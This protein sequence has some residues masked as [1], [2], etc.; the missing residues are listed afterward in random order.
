MDTEQNIEWIQ[1]LIRNEQQMET[2]GLID[3]SPVVNKDHIILSSSIEFLKNL[4]SQFIANAD[5]FNQL[6]GSSNGLIKVYGIA[7]THADFM[8]FRN[9]YKL[10]FNML[11]P[12]KI[13]ITF[14]HMSSPF[15]GS[16]SSNSN[17]AVIPDGTIEAAW[18]AFNEIRWVSD[19]KPVNADHLVKFYLRT[20]VQ[21]STK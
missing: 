9:G 19:K 13:Q 21:N 8:V 1:E 5:I 7:K 14:H 4:K 6:K 16:S 2:S 15:L 20:F 12:G 18:G 3:F 17:P 10:V 11:H